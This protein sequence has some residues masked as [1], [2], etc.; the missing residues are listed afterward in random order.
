MNP[1]E[2]AQFADRKQPL[3]SKANI[4]EGIRKKLPDTG[5]AAVDKCIE[6]FAV[7]FYR[8]CGRGLLYMLPGFAAQISLEQACQ[9]WARD[10][11]QKPNS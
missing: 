2:S 5:I 6:A 4:L 8:A 1:M 3:Y 11:A 9:H 7:N 10:D